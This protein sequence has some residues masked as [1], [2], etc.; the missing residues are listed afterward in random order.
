MWRTRKTC[1]VRE[2]HVVVLPVNHVNAFY[3]EPT[4]NTQSH[5]K[6]TYMIGRKHSHVVLPD[7]ASV[8]LWTTYLLSSHPSV[9][10]DNFAH[11]I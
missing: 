5:T 4:T 11:F 9:T 6:Y 2:H 3:M 8:S 7:Y 1:M 10:V